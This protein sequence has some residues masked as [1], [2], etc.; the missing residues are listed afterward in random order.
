[1]NKKT[2]IFTLIFS[3]LISMQLFSQERGSNQ[4]IKALKVSYI[5]EKLVLTPAEAAKFWPVYNK[6]EKERYQLYHVERAKMKKKIEVLGGI[7]KLTEKQAEAFTK[8]MLA[9]EKLDYDTNVR[10]Q[11]AL[12]KVIS[13]K[14][15]I[16]LQIAERDFNRQL[17]RRYKNRKSK[18]KK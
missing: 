6:F 7:D 17:F 15:M 3:L 16:K 11:I 8:D 1:M 10:Y 12:K 4:K 14:K 18:D 2:Y 13:Y 5:T 9:L